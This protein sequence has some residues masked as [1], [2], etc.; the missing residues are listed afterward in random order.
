MTERTA[1]SRLFSTT[2][3]A[4]QQLAGRTDL[5]TTQRY[6]HISPAAKESAIDLLEK[7]PIPDENRG[8]IGGRI[9]N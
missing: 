4:I 6:M 9:E 3:T 7:R 2:A 5:A 1:P 8:R